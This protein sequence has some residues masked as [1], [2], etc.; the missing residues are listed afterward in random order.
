[1]KRSLSLFVIGLIFGGGIGFTIAAGSGAAFEGHDHADPSHH[2]AGMD[3]GAHGVMHDTPRDISADNPPEVSI[4][5]A[6]DPMAG[7]NLHVITRNFAFA[8]QN[9]GGAHVPG[10]GHAHLY[11][12]G[13]KLGRLYGEWYHID[14]L[15]KG[16]VEIK[17]TLNA[18][19]H[20]PLAVAGTLISASEILTL[21]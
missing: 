3:H 13:E 14:A 4:A 2:V 20:S 8:P 21:E 15:P 7:H 6:P 12:N 16:K 9:A 19:D 1:M 18:N 17:V 11:V 5:V 10:E